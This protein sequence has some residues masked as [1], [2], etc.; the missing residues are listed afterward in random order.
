M[1]RA[2]RLRDLLAHESVYST[3]ADAS[4]A[5]SAGSPRGGR[6]A[7]PPARSEEDGTTPPPPGS[8]DGDPLGR[9][10]LYSQSLA[11]AVSG[12]ARR[13]AV[14][15]QISEDAAAR[16]IAARAEHVRRTALPS[17]PETVSSATLD[18]TCIVCAA[19]WLVLRSLERRVLE[20]KGGGE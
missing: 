2:R 5:A 7:A 10:M 6:D 20:V 17:I 16:R 13:L 8:V 4:T 14:Y 9:D 18:A 3:P 11:T 1:S 15:E 12:M 19:A